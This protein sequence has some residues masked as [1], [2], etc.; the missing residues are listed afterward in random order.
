MHLFIIGAGHVGLVSASGFRSLGHRVTVAD[1][2]EQRIDGLR[3][4][5][6]PIYEPGLEEASGR[7]APTA[8]WRS[9]VGNRPAAGRFLLVRRRV[10]AA[11][12]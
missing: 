10:D 12:R 3:E 1:I 8:R 2:Q 4:G 7:R 6:P 5:V 11:G 9:Q